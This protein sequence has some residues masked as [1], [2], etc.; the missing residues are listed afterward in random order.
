MNFKEAINT[1]LTTVQLEDLCERLGIET[2]RSGTSVK[3]LC[4]F[5][6]DT[7]PS[8]ELYDKNIE[9]SAFHCFSCGAHGDIFALVKEVKG[10]DF[11]EAYKWL[12]NEYNLKV[13]NTSKHKKKPLPIIN[14]TENIYEYAL[15]FYKKNQ[16]EFKYKSF[17]DERGYSVEFGQNTGLCMVGT[18]SLV[19]HLDSLDYP[20]HTHKLYVF[21]QYESAGL[22]KKNSL[23]EEVNKTKHLNLE[24]LYYDHF[25]QGRL[26]FPLRNTN[27]E[28]KG[29]AGRLTY[30]EL[31][32]KYLFTKGLDKSS[33]L[34]RSENAFYNISK[35]RTTKSKNRQVVPIFVCEGLFD[36]LRLESKGFHAV[37]VLGSSLT[38]KQCL[39]I[40]ELSKVVSKKNKTLEVNLFFDNDQAGV[41][42]TDSA[43]RKIFKHSNLG[44]ID[45]KVYHSK[46][47]KKVDPDCF[48]KNINDVN[49]ALKTIEYP[50]PA[51]NLAVE[52]NISTK[53]IEDNQTVKD[54]PYSLKL[55]ASKNWH[56]LFKDNQSNVFLEEFD[57][58]YNTYSWFKLL[59][60]ISLNS[61]EYTKENSGVF[62]N[63]EKQRVHLAFSV[64][65]SS[66]SNA[67]LFP[68]NDAEWRRIEM[69]LP[70]L[71]EVISDR[72]GAFNKNLQPIEPLNT[73]YVPREIAGSE[74]REMSMH[75]VEDLTSHQ[76]ILSELLTE[77]CDYI[78]N[79]S[80]N[81]PA[82]RF[83]RKSN[84][85]VTTGEG[86]KSE[87][88]LTL[89]FAYQIDMEVV[90]GREVPNSDGMFRPY[91]QCWKEFT[92]SINHAANQMSQV[93]MVRLDL[94]RYYD[95]LKRYVLQSALRDC[96]PDDLQKYS[97]ESL[98]SLVKDSGKDKKSKTIDWLLE[99]SFGYNKYHPKTGEIE[100]SD[101]YVG[102]PQG[103][104]ISSF[105]ANLVLF[106][107]DNAAR[108]FLE[109]NKDLETDRYTSWYAR[110]VD[111][112][113]L[114]AED[115]ST[116]SQLR[117]VVE[118]AVKTLELELVAKEQ[119][120]PMT[121]EEFEVYLTQGKA[122]AS[123][124]PT[125]VVELVDIDEI[126]FVG[127]IERYQALSLLNNKDLYSDDVDTIK[128]KVHMAMHCRQ[129]RFSDLK[130]VVKW[131]WFISTNSVT[132]LTTNHIVSRYQELWAEV[133]SHMK[134]QL[135]PNKY[136]W[137]DPLL[138]AFDGLN[139]VISRSNSWVNDSLTQEN[140]TNKEEVRT[141]LI[142]LINSDLLSCLIN[143]NPKRIDGW[144]I[145][146]TELT[147]I[148]WQKKTSLIWHAKQYNSKEFKEETHE[149]MI[150]SINDYTLKNSLVRT[151]FTELYCKDSLKFSLS[152]A[153]YGNAPKDNEFRRICILIQAIY[154]II[155]KSKDETNNSSDLLASVM[156][157]ISDVVLKLNIN[158]QS[159]KI[160][161]LFIIDNESDIEVD[162][163]Q[164]LAVKVLYFVCSLT[165]DT[166]LIKLLSLRWKKLLNGCF[167]DSEYN[168]ITPIPLIEGHT[169]YGYQLENKS[170]INKLIRITTNKNNESGDLY[171]S[172]PDD[173]NHTKWESIDNN[174]NKD[175]Y[176]HTVNGKALK[177][178]NLIMSTPPASINHVNRN[179]L[180][181]VADTYKSLI[182]CSIEGN[183]IP[184][185]C[186]TSMSSISSDSYDLERND[187]CIIAS[188]NNSNS[189]PQAFIRNGARGLRPI[190]VP[191]HNIK[192]W[193]AGVAL[194]D[195]LGFTRDLDE[196]ANVEENL[197][198]YN[199]SPQSRLLKNSLK[200]LN[201]SIYFSK[202]TF[203]TKDETIPK[204]IQR[205]LTLLE[206]FPNTGKSSDDYLFGFASEME[207][208]LMR[209]RLSHQSNLTEDG[210][211]P[212]LYGRA[213]RAC[214]ERVP[215]DWFSYLPK[216]L[217]N[218]T[219]DKL[220]NLRES[221]RFWVILHS[222][223]N[224]AN[225]NSS[226]NDNHNDVEVTIRSILVGCQVNLI[227]SSLRAVTFEA[228]S[229]EAVKANEFEELAV[230]ESLLD[231]LFGSEFSIHKYCLYDAS[232]ESTVEAL[233]KHYHSLLKDKAVQHVF[234]SITP[235]GW[236]FIALTKKGLLQKNDRNLDKAQESV[237]AKLERSE[238]VKFVAMKEEPRSNNQ[239]PLEF[240]VPTYNMDDLLTELDLLQSIERIS[241]KN[242][243]SE[244]FSYNS[245][246]GEFKELWLLKKW[247]IDVSASNATDNKPFYKTIDNQL[248]S[249]WTESYKDDNLLY[250]SS[251]G[252]LHGGILNQIFPESSRTQEKPDP[253]QTEQV[254]LPPEPNVA[255]HI[256]KTNT[257]T[258]LDLVS[259]PELTKK[260]NKPTETE[261]SNSDLDGILKRVNDMH[262]SSW[263][264]RKD[265]RSPSHIRIAMFQ[266]DLKGDLGDGYY[267]HYTKNGEVA[268]NCNLGTRCIEIRDALSKGTIEDEIRN[269]LL[270]ELEGCHSDIECSQLY[271]DL[272]LYNL[273]E[274]RRKALLKGAIESCIKLGV[275]L[276]VLPEYS[277]QPTTILWLKKYLRGKK[278]SILAGTYR[279][280]E[281]YPASKLKELT[282]SVYCDLVSSFQSVMT[283]LVPYENDKVLCFN[284]AKKYASPAA[285]ELIYPYQHEIQPLFS[286]EGFEKQLLNDFPESSKAL[287]LQE[288]QS[289]MSSR[290]INLL[291]F[292]QELICAELFLLTNPVNYLNLAS[293]YKN[294]SNKFGDYKVGTDDDAIEAVLKDIKSLSFNLSGNTSDGSGGFQPYKRSIVTIPA[295][296]SRKQDYWI[297]GQGAMLAN[298]I[299]TIFCNAVC[300][301]EST[302]GSCFI[303]LDSWIGDK[304]KPFITPYSGWSKGIYYGERS[305]TLQKEQ[306]LVIADIDPK[307]MSLGSPRPQALPVPMKLV[308]H[309]PVIELTSVENEKIDKLHAALS[310][311]ESFNDKYKA[312]MLV[313]PV[314]AA[315]L[316][317]QFTRWFNVSCGKDEKESLNQRINSWNNSWRIN[318]QVGIAALTDWLVVDIDRPNK[319]NSNA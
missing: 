298:G 276:L 184:T 37:A 160:L 310:S 181:W 65:K 120:T 59:T 11:H 90:E 227:E 188:K 118:E 289:L 286:L 104:D 106:K 259:I 279:L 12:C 271:Q 45:I 122:L 35:V 211:L 261:E 252:K 173:L 154:L 273:A 55:R 127:R 34:Y 237:L 218:N 83:Y 58:K 297:F 242:I 304:T 39:M 27:G 22:I 275:D 9:K 156:G 144:A 213:L 15:D 61:T 231:R 75:C 219:L 318:P 207:T 195:M 31:G 315:D 63:D 243:N 126:E 5:H 307:M 54:L 285:N 43:I 186:N 87:Y 47:D 269:K 77:R 167:D 162:D 190:Q 205:T 7:K 64:S 222:A 233:G 302:G 119:P 142:K 29:F 113:V 41:K 221:E 240:D 159:R 152:E 132:E 196:Y 40:V 284:R 42:A 267:T 149:N 228:Q 236:F 49:R 68:E 85:T 131:L 69:C 249:N 197:G 66:M 223:F 245:V 86:G 125:G 141:K 277:V 171:S 30:S 260:V 114:I 200:K 140:I 13:E 111:D 312:N 203:P 187:V 158:Y 165:S 235:L 234:D 214:I 290:H 121:S 206:N 295:M 176:V 153:S 239:W 82:T 226:F 204:S 138:L 98:F 46:E 139:Q 147:R 246:K 183:K 105:L 220:S 129:L 133:T 266:I 256:Y 130:K 182:D 172:K 67:G 94:K 309:I 168:L 21:D 301:T 99:Q 50:F 311:F 57:S 250:I 91:F 33:L 93:N 18:S 209:F 38:D 170:S 293:E 26:L 151:Y 103:P 306:S 70:L 84:T 262:S 72:F 178:S 217:D 255:E 135:V 247:Q 145:S 303:G 1:L 281:G 78:D 193:Q 107:V 53:E 287:G 201:G 4:Q 177:Q 224:N 169:L 308:A 316:I 283:L 17:L 268:N 146:K 112:M 174:N 191:N 185:W 299:S 148:Y 157:E 179:V 166:K 229:S 51:I 76:Y 97:D 305:D 199:E 288:I 117:I 270:G 28:I 244:H 128:S 248:F 202:P 210:K 60:N 258:K 294:L 101:P 79:F 317:Q 123:S 313:D 230:D 163:C 36:A 257:P 14:A 225:N 300:G 208:Q 88:S 115:S 282:N 96:I 264:S 134:K 194:T 189:F 136:P 92:Q 254:N 150:T 32:P 278:I 291:S 44:D 161:N 48:L 10:I 102:I 2:K 80:L 73:I 56:N 52:L 175:L 19:K 71:E 180:K 8:M 238:L 109:K 100:A 81:I 198:D 62:I 263:R 108:N 253:I 272:A 116:L 216:D 292:M 251:L 6:T 265:N 274:K 20:E 241:L 319:G 215:L 164:D 137:E 89:S 23:S 124:G 280:P 192:F 232:E 155:S 3:A 143:S 314:Q 296:T 74:Y 95:R 212:Q 24:N 16:N 110:Y 25:K